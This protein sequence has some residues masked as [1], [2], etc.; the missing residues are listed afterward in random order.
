V[1]PISRFDQLRHHTDAV[2]SSPDAAFEYLRHTQRLG[3]LADVLVLAFERERGCAGDD[4][5][6]GMRVNALMISSASPSLKYSFSLSPLM[7][8]NGST[9]IDGRSSATL[10]DMSSS[11][12]R[13]SRIVWEAIE[14]LFGEASPDDALD[15]RRRTERG[16]IVA[17]HRADHMRGAITVERAPARQQLVQH[18]TEAEDIRARVERLASAC[19]GDM[20]AAVPMTAPSMVRVASSALPG[21][22]LHQLG[23]A[24]SSNL[25]VC[26]SEDPP[27]RVTSTFPGFQVT[28]EDAPLMGRIERPGNLACD[29]HC[30]V[31]SHRTSQLVTIDVLEHEIAWTDVVKLADVRVVECRDRPCL[32]LESSEPV[33]IGGERLGKNL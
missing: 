28:M 4:F 29:P 20:Y 26:G 1:R 11:A 23:N 18:R 33:G 2:A 32:L 9:T 17:Q 16:G 3:D 7:F 30:I 19:S 10:A 15:R 6:S 21:R 24:K 13:T 12:A 5:Q 25:A 14:R 8:S 27:P 22:R 31:H